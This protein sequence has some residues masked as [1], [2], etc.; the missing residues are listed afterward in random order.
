MFEARSIPR[1]SSGER[2]AKATSTFCMYVILSLFFW[3]GGDFEALD[4]C[5]F[6]PGKP[7]IVATQGKLRQIETRR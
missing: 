2:E 4:T 5:P 3:G 1:F 6:F 7:F